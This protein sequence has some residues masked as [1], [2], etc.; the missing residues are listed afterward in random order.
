MPKKHAGSQDAEGYRKVGGRGAA[1]DQA[2]GSH[3]R[4]GGKDGIRGSAGGGGSGSGHGFGKGG[5]G[6]GAGG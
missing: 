4:H 2:G 6:N 3:P 5:G 1:R